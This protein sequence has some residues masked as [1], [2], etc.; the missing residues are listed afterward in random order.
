MKTIAIYIR[1]YPLTIISGE[2]RIL[3]LFYIYTAEQSTNNTN[4]IVPILIYS[5]YY[6][7]QQL[8]KRY[9]N[10]L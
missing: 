8:F 10:C 5:N 6:L 4:R 1:K 7:K 2:D 3:H 9:Y